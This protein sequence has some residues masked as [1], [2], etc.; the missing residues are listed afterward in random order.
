MF[1]EWSLKSVPT[2]DLRLKR[3]PPFYYSPPV[4]QT[5]F[6]IL[7]RDQGYDPL[8]YAYAVIL[9]ERE[10]SLSI[11]L[12]CQSTSLRFKGSTKVI[13]IQLA[14]TILGYPTVHFGSRRENLELVILIHFQM[15]VV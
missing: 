1:M 11:L 5:A 6:V 12:S 3:V 2:M 8:L 7:Y 15:V 14:C 4:I 9:G 10:P 13:L